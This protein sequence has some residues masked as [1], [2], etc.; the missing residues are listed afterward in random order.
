MKA[1]KTHVR[2]LI[3][4]DGAVRRRAILHP[5]YNTRVLELGSPEVGA[6]FM[7]ERMRSPWLQSMERQKILHLGFPSVLRVNGA[8]AATTEN[9]RLSMPIIPKFTS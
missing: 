8:R 3:D 2:D 1:C 9:E 6:P 7:Q 5:S 4:S